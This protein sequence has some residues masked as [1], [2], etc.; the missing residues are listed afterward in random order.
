LNE[1]HED[2]IWAYPGRASGKSERN[3]V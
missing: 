2:A 3:I 1:S